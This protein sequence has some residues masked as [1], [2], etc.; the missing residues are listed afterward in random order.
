MGFFKGLGLTLSFFVVAALLVGCASLSS[1]PSSS[2]PQKGGIPF[3]PSSTPVSSTLK[4]PSNGLTQSNSGGAVTLD[5]K[6]QGEGSGVLAFAVVMDTHSV[7]LDKYDLGKLAVL[8]D[9]GGN[10]YRPTSWRA[11][12]GGHHRSGTLSFPVPNSMNQGKVKYLEL[13]VKDV[14][15]VKERVL[16][17]EL[18]EG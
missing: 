15:G 14:A 7:D 5:A 2:S 9:D 12:P 8:R 6:W 16:K 13:V 3:S 4:S 18:A 11:A 17:W 10:E 1:F